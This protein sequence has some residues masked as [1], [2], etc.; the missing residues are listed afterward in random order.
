MSMP[1]PEA[2][3]NRDWLALE[4]SIAVADGSVTPLL[5]S[6]SIPP[7]IFRQ[8]YV[9]LT[10]PIDKGP[11]IGV[12]SAVAGEGRSTVAFGLARTLAADLDTTV[13]LVD[14]NLD[15]PSL[16]QRLNMPTSAGLSGVLRG[17]ASLAD[18][19]YEV[20]ERLFIVS[21]HE[22]D[23]ESDRLLRELSEHDPFENRR[24][25][26]AVTILDLPPVLDRSYTSL[27][28]SVT[29]ALV[30]VIRAGATPVEVLREAIERLTDRPLQGAVLNAEGPRQR[31]WHRRHR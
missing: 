26:G 27:A 28:S 30:L 15:R 29:D 12:T 3:M 31:F 2:S 14:A 18:V 6:A 11:V 17:K 5:V 1:A 13:L 20:D 25:V 22:A 24:A 8:I 21:S 9:S 23:N 10:L 16:A 4:H 19:M 7:E